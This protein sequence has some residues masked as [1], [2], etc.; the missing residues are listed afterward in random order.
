M[1]PIQ[2][3]MTGTKPWPTPLVTPTLTFSLTLNGRYCGSVPPN[4]EVFHGN[5]SLASVPLD[6]RCPL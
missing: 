5:E 2:A 3:P 1:K 4:Y 6:G